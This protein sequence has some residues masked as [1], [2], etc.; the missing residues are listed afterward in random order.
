MTNDLLMREAR[1]YA[2]RNG[3]PS[4]MMRVVE[5]L[6]Q[7]AAD[8]SAIRVA[9]EAE[10]KAK[11]GVGALAEMMMGAIPPTDLGAPVPPAEPVDVGGTYED[12]RL[13]PDSDTGYDVL[14]NGEWQPATPA[15]IADIRTR[16]AHR[17]R[18]SKNRSRR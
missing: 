2:S 12:W 1:D 5:L 7:I 8:V 11:V 15:Q 14:H 6:E 13:K 17:P 16:I 18:G 10:S 4:T 3:K 9:T